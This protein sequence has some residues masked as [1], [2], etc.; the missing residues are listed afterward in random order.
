MK[1][2]QP[3][4]ICKTGQCTKRLLPL[5]FK[6]SPLSL[7]LS[8][9]CLSVLL[10]GPA[11]TFA[12]EFDG[13]LKEVKITDSSG[14]NQ[15]P[16]A[17]LTYTQSGSIFTFDASGSSDPDGTIAEYKWDFGDGSTA[18]GI[19]ASHQFP[20]GTYNVTLTLIDINGGVALVQ[21]KISGA[22]VYEDAEDGTTTGWSIY[23]NV[24]E[25]ATISNITDPDNGSKVIQFRGAGTDNGFKLVNNDGSNWQATGRTV[26]QWN[27]KI[28]STGF[29]IFV[30]VNT[31]A[32]KRYLQYTQTNGD[33]LGTSTY[34]HHGLGTIIGAWYTV[35]RDLQADLNEAQPGV[36]ILEVNAFLIKAD[37]M[38]DNI[39]LF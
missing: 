23:D 6:L 16:S 7:Q 31:T 27:M 4:N 10:F 39:S 35:N 3:V 38:V 21:K 2:T 9:F 28:A 5:S 11:Q 36:N 34:V 32:G 24:P 14:T 30:E 17:V 20:S 12:A 13:T 22:V 25:G 15:P 1:T 19:T 29:N 8:A 18:T 33:N 26:I 37:G